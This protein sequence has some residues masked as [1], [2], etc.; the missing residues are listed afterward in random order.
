M[1]VLGDKLFLGT[2]DAHLVALDIKTGDVVWDRELADY[3]KGYSIT[4]APIVVKD[5]VIV[6][7]AGAEF[8][9]RGFIEA[10]DVN[11]GKSVWKFYT[12]AWTRSAGRSDMAERIERLSPRRRL[13]LGDGH[14]RPRAEP[15]LLRNR[16]SRS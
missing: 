13:D 3:T 6:G 10:M 16:Q 12:V 11:T 8:G 5:K 9:I 2:G 4:V 15:G 1:A 7:M 14:L